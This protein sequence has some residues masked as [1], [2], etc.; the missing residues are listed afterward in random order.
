[1]AEKRV[2]RWTTGH[3]PVCYDKRGNSAKGAREQCA[4]KH[5][6]T[7]RKKKPDGMGTVRLWGKM[8]RDPGVLVAGTVV[9]G[10][11]GGLTILR[12]CRLSVLL[13]HLLFLLIGADGGTG[14]TANRTAD[15]ST[16]PTIAVTGN[17]STDT[18]AGSTSGHGT[19]LC[20]GASNES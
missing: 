16:G 15:E 18:G 13:L 3:C 9:A 20:G 4:I 6:D 10:S 7:T 5:R 2:G 8:V 12:G 11:R 17:E 1:M 19:L 14:E